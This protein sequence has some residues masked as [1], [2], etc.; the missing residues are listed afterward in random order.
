MGIK[1]TWGAETIIEQQLPNDFYNWGTLPGG[2]DG[3]VKLEVAEDGTLLDSGQWAHFIHGFE[4]D[5]P[6]DGIKGSTHVWVNYKIEDLCQTASFNGDVVLLNPV[7]LESPVLGEWWWG[8]TGNH[9][10]YNAHT[11]PGQRFSI[12][13]VQLDSNGKSYSGDDKNP[14]NDKFYAW[15]QPVYCM[16]SGTVTEA[17]DS[18]MDNNGWTALKPL[19]PPNYVT[20][21]HNNGDVSGYY[22]FRQ[23]GVEVAKND[24]VKT[25]DLLGYVGNSGGSSEPHLHFGYTKMTPTGRANLYPMQ[26]SNLRTVANL[27][28]VS[29]T[30]GV[31]AYSSFKVAG[32]C[33]V[34]LWFKTLLV[35]LFG[36]RRQSDIRAKR[37]GSRSGNRYG[38]H[39]HGRLDYFQRTIDD[40][41]QAQREKGAN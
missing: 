13:L 26:F 31:D 41:K 11:W 21:Q 2:N 7:Q 39:M 25:G 38:H 24:V 20:V 23:G 27:T 33:I 32:F 5:L 19:P 36:G 17:D 8:S 10:G 9:S 15:D 30:P 3:W 34:V 40:F 6:N 28:P 1:V 22:H 35:K 16:K 29:A 12:D 37:M 4:I 14:T 18:N